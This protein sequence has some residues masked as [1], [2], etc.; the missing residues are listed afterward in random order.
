MLFIPAASVLKYSKCLCLT[1]FC[2]E[3]FLFSPRHLW[4][5]AF[6]FQVLSLLGLPCRLSRKASF[7]QC[8]R[9]G[10]DPCVGKISWRRKWQP[11]PVFLP[12]KSQGQRSLAGYSPRG[13]NK[14]DVTQGLNNSNNKFF[15]IKLCLHLKEQ[16]K[17]D[18]YNLSI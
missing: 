10:F 18:W 5:Y 13:R 1:I 6:V 2:F 16:T 12:G 15:S 3:S 7:C 17:L 9:L 11:T 4:A 14:S 8:R